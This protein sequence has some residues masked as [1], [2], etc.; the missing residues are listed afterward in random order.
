MRLG[1]SSH[2]FAWAIGVPGYPPPRQPLTAG[3]LLERAVELQVGVVQIADNLPLHELP[4]AEL[5][6]LATFADQ[7]RL[8]LEIGTQGIEPEH[9]RC[10]LKLAQRL[11]SRIV[12]TLLDS[13]GQHP[14]PSEAVATLRQVVPEFAQA[15][16]CLAIENHD[17]FPA[18]VLRDIVDAQD[19]PHVGLCLDTANS[20]GCGEGLDTLL[21]VLGPRAVNL[22]VKDFRVQRLP[23]QKGFVV[24]GCPAGEGLVDLPRLLATLRSH[25]CDP[26]AIV[27]LWVSPLTNLD[28]TIAR[29]AAWVEQSVRCLRQ[30]IVD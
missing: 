10:Y 30:W 20:L 5:R 11:H 19:S 6:S 25:R 13:P 14:T 7:H 21:P 1:I 28:D 27:E 15:G 17:R 24:E 3:R 26:N 29:E 16:V 9:L 8:E 22:H 12:R 4:E 2:A 23:H 18:Q